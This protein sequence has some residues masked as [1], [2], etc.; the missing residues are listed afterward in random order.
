M[1][2]RKPNW[3][4]IRIANAPE[5]KKVTEMLRV[6]KLHTV[7]EE[8][9]CPNLMECFGKRT[10]TFMILGTECTRNCSF[11]NVSKGD[12]MP[13]DPDEPRHVAEAVKTLGLKYVVVTSVTRD[14][15]P[16]GGAGHF[17]KV[18]YEVKQV[19]AD[20]SI[21]V[22]IPDFQGD[23][24]ALRKVL[25]A[26][27]KVLNH[28]IETIKRLYSEVRPMANYERTLELIKRVKQIDPMIHSKSGFMVG[29]GEKSEEVEELLRELRKADCEIVTIGQY[30]A[31]SAKHHPVIEYVR[32]EVFA[33]YKKMAE[34]MGYLYVASAPLVRSSYHAGEAFAE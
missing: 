10:A 6:L 17:A 28:N 34:E 5:L 30:L 11:C 2:E 7:C 16:D 14:D 15:L 31:P 33:E 8:A 32:P 22:L 25:K 3:L 1:V 27:P 13:V 20:T 18:I 24:E 21:E 19:S 26:K 23:E 4:K 12:P 29:L 9:N